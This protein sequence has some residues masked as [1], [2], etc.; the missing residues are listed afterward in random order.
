MVIASVRWDRRG[1]HHQD[2]WGRVALLVPKAGALLDT[3]A[4]LFVDDH[5]AQR[6]ELHRVFDQGVRTDQDLDAAVPQ[7]FVDLPPRG[8]CPVE[9]VSK[10]TGTSVR[11]ASC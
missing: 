5:E 8:P 3:E 2:V 4:V 10:A 7:A 9:P 6:L 1:G 11:R